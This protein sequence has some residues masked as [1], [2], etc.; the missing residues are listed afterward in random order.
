MRIFGGIIRTL[1]FAGSA[2]AMGESLAQGVIDLAAIRMNET[3]KGSMELILQYIVSN[4]DMDN[5]PTF[6][7]V[8]NS[9]AWLGGF[10]MLALT[11]QGIRYIMAADSPA[12]MANTKANVQRLIVGMVMVSFSGLI[13]NLGLDVSSGMAG[14]FVTEGLNDAT[15]MEL[16]VIATTFGLACVMVPAGFIFALLL[17]LAVVLRYMIL[18]ILWALFPLILALYFSQ[19]S[20]LTEVGGRGVNLYLAAIISNPVMALIF[21]VSLDM[22]HAACD[23]TTVSWNVADKFLTFAMSVV[24]LAVAGL[25]PLMMLGI[26]NKAGAVVQV[27]GTAVAAAAGGGVASAFGTYAGSVAGG[28]TLAGD[29]AARLGFNDAGIRNSLEYARGRADEGLKS[30]AAK[31][32]ATQDYDV[33][34]DQGKI[35]FMSAVDLE[36]YGM[37]KEQGI[38]RQD[39][40]DIAQLGDAGKALA[41]KGIIDIG[42]YSEWTA[43]YGRG[44][45]DAVSRRIA[46]QQGLL[47][48]GRLVMKNAAHASYTQ[49]GKE[50]RLAANAAEGGGF[51]VAVEG[52]KNMTVLT[53]ADSGRGRGSQGI[54]QSI[55]LD[56]ECSKVSPQKVLARMHR[57]SSMVDFG[58]CKKKFEKAAKHMRQGRQ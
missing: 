49:A 42:G 53:V 19:M 10:F 7:A 23:P 6:T 57:Q 17:L 28:I 37:L 14:A 46:N 51:N 12:S 16:T 25:T 41:A 21:K 44:F 48:D 58:S 11:Y 24:G 30:A 55:I 8:H 38:V 35:D 3:F 52:P 18:L 22:M 13:F 40:S 43:P 33:G 45:G 34:T 56:S 27:A 31:V 50:Y 5:W 47:S 1:F 2:S 29:N 36:R 9:F 39:Q 54:I 4:P 15:G 32:A 26:L 20:F